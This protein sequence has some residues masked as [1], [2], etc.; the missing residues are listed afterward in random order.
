MTRDVDNQVAE[1]EHLDLGLVGQMRAAEERANAGHELARRE[2]LDEVV[3]CAQLE[4]DDAVL[5]LALS[6]EHDDGHVGGVANR[7]ADAL[8]G[9]L[10]EHEV[11]YDKVELVLLEFLDSGLPVA[12]AH[13]IVALALEIGRNGIADSLLV[14][15]EQNFSCVRS[16]SE[17]S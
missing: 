15:N 3:V 13:D 9:Q 17:A 2:R 1:V 7:T 4:T 8:A 12:Y 14:F 11:E 16:H 5:H 10:G 6:G